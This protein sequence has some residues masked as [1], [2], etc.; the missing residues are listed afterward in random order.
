MELYSDSLRSI[1]F[2]QVS[3]NKAVLNVYITLSTYMYICVCYY[4]Y[5]V[6]NPCI[7]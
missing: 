1:S 7:Y 5:N 6:S 4:C 3:N 2:T